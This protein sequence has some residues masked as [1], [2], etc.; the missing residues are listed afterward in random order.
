MAREFPG[1]PMA[2]TH[3]SNP[4]GLGFNPCSGN[5]IPHAAAKTQC[6]QINKVKKK[7]LQ[8]RE[9]QVEILCGRS[10]SACLQNIIESQNRVNK[11]WV[12][13]DK[14]PEVAG[15]SFMEGSM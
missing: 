10:L 12:V 4:V 15:S 11:G 1:S 7:K 2:K 3:A 13:G 5:Q 9:Q 14:V 6:R 8:A